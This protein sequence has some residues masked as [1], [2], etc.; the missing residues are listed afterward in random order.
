L[1][2]SIIIKS[3]PIEGL[4]IVPSTISSQSHHQCKI[5]SKIVKKGIAIMIPPRKDINR[6]TALYN[7]KQRNNTKSQYVDVDMY[8]KS[9]ENV[10]D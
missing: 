2:L 8:L 5:I 6:E 4:S 1:I 10:D 9:K 7:A 3:R